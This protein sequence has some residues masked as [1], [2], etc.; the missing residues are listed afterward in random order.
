MK[1]C[2]PPLGG[3]LVYNTTAPA[4]I[5]KSNLLPLKLFCTKPCKHTPSHLEPHI[6]AY[7]VHVQ[8]EEQRNKPELSECTHHCFPFCCGTGTWSWTSRMPS[9]VG[10]RERGSWPGMIGLVEEPK[11]ITSCNVHVHPLRL[12]SQWLHVHVYWEI[13]C[14]AC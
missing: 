1:A 12:A 6:V 2:R 8:I 10:E 11:H 7:S 9:I 3:T 5:F 14:I 13:V 4:Q